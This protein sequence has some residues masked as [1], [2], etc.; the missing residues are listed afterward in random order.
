MKKIIE[1]FFRLFQILLRRDFVPLHTKL[2]A[3]IL[4][5]VLLFGSI[6]LYITNTYVIK[7]TREE[8]NR[9]GQLVLRI[10]QE[11]LANDIIFQDFAAVNFFINE[12]KNSDPDIFYILVFDASKKLIGHT[13]ETNQIP[14]ALTQLPETSKMQLL[15]DPQAGIYIRQLYAPIME[16][17]LGYLL[18]GLNETNIKTKGE[19]LA[20]ILIGMV[21]GFLF[22]GIV[23]AIGFSSYITHP[24]YEILDGFRRFVPGKHL[25][26]LAIRTNDELM[27]LGEGFQQMMERISALDQQSRQTQLK[28]METEKLASV[29]ILASGIAHEIN[30]PIAGIEL[31]LHRLL[32]NPGGF[33]AKQREYLESISESTQHIKSIVGNLLDYSH[34]ADFK[35]ESLNLKEVVEFAIRL[36]QFRLQKNQIRLQCELPNKPFRV[37]GGKAQLIQVVVNCLL[38]AIDAVERQGNI[39]LSLTENS[40]QYVLNISDDGCG[41]PEDIVKQIFDPFFTTK[42]NRGT[43]LGLYVSYNIIKVHNGTIS[44]TSKPGEGTTVTITLPRE[45]GVL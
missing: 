42:G 38:N 20:V 7:T 44:V 10:L 13:F 40:N 16:G 29:G 23:G 18:L 34:H 26:Q 4:F 2:V 27:L 11:E 30:N 37:R 17:R 19:H 1:L 35:T 41:I 14:V 28:M 36:V 33:D 25:P 5:V 8:M 45:N 15:K 6:N 32:K 3:A 39:S 31:C 22:L 12:L 24:I 21:M 43:G 9:K